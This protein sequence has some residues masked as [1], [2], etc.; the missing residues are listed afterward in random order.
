MPIARVTCN[1]ET[2]SPCDGALS[3]SSAPVLNH[4]SWIS[5]Q[6]QSYLLERLVKR[7]GAADGIETSD[8]ARTVSR[9]AGLLS[10]VFPGLRQVPPR[11]YGG[12]AAI[13]VLEH[14]PQEDLA[15][16]LTCLAGALWPKSPLL[17]VT[18]DASELASR[19]RGQA[20]RALSDP[21]HINLQDTLLGVSQSRKL[22]S[23]LSKKEPRGC[24]ARHAGEWMVD[25]IHLVPVALQVLTSRLLL[26]AGNGESSVFVTRSPA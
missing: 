17:V 20:W 23:P 5:A 2:A 14:I 3:C 4:P 13:H 10:T 1:T 21:T 8:H 25:R 9:E 26:R 19:L 18:P 16:T 6:A 24:G 11:R 12:C 22:L 15:E 7:F